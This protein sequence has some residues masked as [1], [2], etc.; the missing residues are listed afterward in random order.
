MAELDR[1]LEELRWIRDRLDD[2]TDAEE[3]DRLETR[4]DELR[5]A[6]QL[7]MPGTPAS[8]D[9]VRRELEAAERRL[10]DLLKRRI[11]VVRQAGGSMGGDFGFTADAMKINR[12]IDKAQDR[13][14]LEARIRALRAR[15]QELER[16]S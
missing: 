11:D 12:E 3:R 7:A 16:E 15:L 6:A 14:G 10:D 4:R 8:V 9:Q 13:T 5:V 2:V 1:I